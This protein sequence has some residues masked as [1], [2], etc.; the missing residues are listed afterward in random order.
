MKNIYKSKFWIKMFV[1][2]AFVVSLGLVSCVPENEIIKPVE[3]NPSEPI[4]ISAFSPDSGRVATQMLI[5]GENFGGDAGKI[6][7]FINDKKAAVV[8]VNPQGTLIYCIVPSLRGDEWRDEGEQ[9]T[10]SVKVRVGSAESNVPNKMLSYT[11][12]KNVSTFLGFTDQDGNT[13]IVDGAFDKAQFQSPF[14]LA[15]DNDYDGPKVNGKIRKNIYL[16]EE[17]NG[18]RFIDLYKKTVETIFRTNGDLQRPRTIAF[19]LNRDEGIYN[20]DT[21]IIANDAGEWH[22][23]GTVIIPR[24]SITRKFTNGAAVPWTA[25][26]HHKQCNGGAIHPISGDYW[27]NS[28]QNSQVYKVFQHSGIPWRYGGPTATD[29]NEDGKEGTKYFFLVQD[30]GWEFNIQIAPSGSFAY[31]VSK[32]QHYIARMEYNFEKKAFDKPQ[33]FVGSQKRAGF[34]DGVGVGNT[35]FREPQQGA[36]DKFDNFYVCDGEN[37][38]IRKVTP[39][40]QVSTFAGRP[41]NPGFSD[42]ALRDAQFDGPFGIIYDDEINT[43][44]IADRDNRRIRTIKVE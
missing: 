25:V 28:Y 33:P 19:T 1:S 20:R 35:L 26:M 7:V 12:T 6:S 5:R 32:N 44:Y 36:F 13:A 8:G 11:F 34:K 16:I 17:N 4:T 24:D 31:I 14:W 23:N 9:T 18:L 15:F 39:N 40:G 37:N 3:Y 42:G 41:E 29:L 30:N 10:A 21:M 22:L 27:F 38:C 2:A 43:F